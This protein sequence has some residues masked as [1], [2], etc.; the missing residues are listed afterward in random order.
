MSNISQFKRDIKKLSYSVVFITDEFVTDVVK[1]RFSL[2]K[3][4]EQQSQRTRGDS[5][6]SIY[7]LSSLNLCSNKKMLRRK[8]HIKAN[9]A[10]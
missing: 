7:F 10:L 6:L 8:T 4:S 2:N 5:C 3:I 9:S 1:K